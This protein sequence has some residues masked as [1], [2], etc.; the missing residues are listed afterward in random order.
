MPEPNYAIELTPPDIEPYRAGN[1]GVEYV[2]TFDSGTS[3]PHVLVTA[4][5]HGNEIC[6]AIALD[7]LFRTGLRPRRGKLTLAFDNIA[8]YQSFDRRVPTASRFV[9]EDFNRLWAPATLD[10]QRQSTELARA[11]VLRPFVDAADFLLDIHSMQYATAPLMLAGT[12]DRSLALARRVGIPELIMCDAGHAAGPRMRDYGGFGEPTSPKTALLIE[13]GQHWER[14]A[15]EVATDVMLRFLITVGT[16]AREDARPLGG[17]DFDAHPRQRTIQVTEAVTI[18][19]ASFE[20]VQNFR[21]LEVLPE[22]GTLI[23]R[24]DGREVRTPYDNCVLIM[25]SR[26]L[27]KGQTAVRLGRYLA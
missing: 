15:A 22:K 23:G 2:T 18:T 12:L 1:T 19:G 26:R 4:L 3:G 24:D 9:D 14:R 20:F 6:G 7:Q 16:F 25:P 5:T 11:R 27:V 8:A 17:P 13:A 21:G 10:G